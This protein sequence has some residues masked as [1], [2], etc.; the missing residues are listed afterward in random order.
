MS[1]GFLPAPSRAS[2]FPCS[3]CWQSPT[4]TR[5][6]TSMPASSS[7]TAPQSTTHACVKFVNARFASCPQTSSARGSPSLLRSSCIV[8]RRKSRR[9]PRQT[10]TARTR[11]TKRR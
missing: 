9:A 5:P 4:S 8:R 7:E 6:Q 1:G 11:T 2:L 3:P 10:G